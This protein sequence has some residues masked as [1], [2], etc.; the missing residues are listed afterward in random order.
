MYNQPIY[1]IQRATTPF[2][3]CSSVQLQKF[4]NEF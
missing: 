1:T 3:S 4:T 2:E